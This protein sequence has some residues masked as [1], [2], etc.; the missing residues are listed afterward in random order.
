MLKLVPTPHLRSGWLL[1]RLGLH[2]FLSATSALQSSIRSVLV[3]SVI[4]LP[5]P[6]LH[7]VSLI[8]AISLSLINNVELLTV[9]P[10]AEPDTDIVSASSPS[11]ILSSLTIKLNLVRWLEL[12]SA[13]MV[14]SNDLP[15]LSFTLYVKSPVEPIVA[16]PP[17]TVTVILV[18]VSK[19]FP[20]VKLAVT[21]IS[22]GS[23]PSSTS[24]S[25]TNSLASSSPSTSISV[26]KIK[27]MAS[28][29][30]SASPVIVNEVGM[31]VNPSAEPDT[32]TVSSPSLATLSFLTVNSNDSHHLV[33]PAGI[34]ISNLLLSLLVLKSELSA[35]A[36]PVAV[37]VT[38]TTVLVGNDAEFSGKDAVTV[39]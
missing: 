13:G 37:T 3:L 36:V 22:V 16:L 30:I 12:L 18:S 10:E 14:I 19:A 11:Y 33:I 8:S 32:I 6:A 9:K 7:L 4:K 26:S 21:Y 2:K 38:G 27:E 20:L 34:I 5:T 17:D 25:T 39:T 24:S 15:C 1:E 28:G 35:V 23:L 29:G 31:T